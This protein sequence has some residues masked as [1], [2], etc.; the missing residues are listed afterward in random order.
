M[1]G[2]NQRQMD[3]TRRTAAGRIASWFGSEIDALVLV[4]RDAVEAA[5]AR[6]S[7]ALDQ[8]TADRILLASRA[9]SKQVS[10]LLNLRQEPLLEVTSNLGQALRATLAEYPHLRERGIRGEI[11]ESAALPLPIAALRT[12][13]KELLDN[14]CEA[15]AA[16][17]RLEL[18]EQGGLL[19]LRVVSE[20]DLSEECAGLAPFPFFTTK[21]GHP[22][23]GLSL[24][25]A[26]AENQR[27]CL[28]IALPS[29]H[30]SSREVRIGVELPTAP[31]VRKE[32]GPET[33]VSFACHLAAALAHD[34]NNALMAALGWAEILADARSEEERSES[35]ATLSEAADYLESISYLL[36]YASRPARAGG[37]LDLEQAFERMRPLLRA[38]LEHKADRKIALQVQAAARARTVMSE[39]A[40]RSMVLRLAEN[41]RDGMPNGGTWAIA[42]DGEPVV[43]FSAEVRHPP[44]AVLEQRPR[45]GGHG[46]ARVELGLAVVRDL[47]QAA[48]GAFEIGPESPPSPTVC[49]R[50]PGAAS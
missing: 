29:P 37:T 10:T 32:S 9:C 27:G 45:P 38:V 12:V 20:A 15:S 41:A 33:E 1:Q 34:A 39:D 23:L 30:Q 22:G 40:L 26:A 8:R 17:P 4:L 6:S 25:H 44:T 11:L 14:A 24:V 36:P 28:R 16:A 47:V 46:E 18:G 35:L 7:K 42:W 48:G 49:V 21:A 5:P 50:L 13:I 19:E 2:V 43:T 3:A 31:E